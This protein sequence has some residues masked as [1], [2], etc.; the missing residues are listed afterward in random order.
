MK[1]P[2]TR[3]SVPKRKGLNR[4]TRRRLPSSNEKEKNTAEENRRGTNVHWKLE[5][6]VDVAHDGCG[7]EKSGGTENSEADYENVMFELRSRRK[8]RRETRW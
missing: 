7:T 8:W 5:L 2:M 6:G 1:S 3:A 4:T